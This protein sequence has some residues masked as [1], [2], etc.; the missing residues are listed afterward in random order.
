MR[1]TSRSP[2]ALLVALVL[3]NHQHHPLAAD[4]LALL[5]HRLNRRSYLHDPFRR[6]GSNGPALAAV[7]AAATG[8]RRCSRARK[9]LAFEQ[10][11]RMVA[12][13]GWRGCSGRIPS[14]LRDQVSGAGTGGEMA[15]GEYPRPIGGDRDRKLGVRRRRA[16]LG[17]DRPAVAP[18]AHGGT[19]GGHHRLDGEHH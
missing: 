8:S 19:P 9:Y 2:L 10:E 13:P 18:D 16:V 12:T 6:L 11:S 4:D 7:V 1:A 3:T 5:A 15:R 14:A 17:V